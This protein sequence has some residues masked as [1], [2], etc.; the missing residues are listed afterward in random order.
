MM[1][2]FL[3]S[4]SAAEEIA[5]MHAVASRAKQQTNRCVVRLP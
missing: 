5:A 2:V 1:I 4:G 3:T